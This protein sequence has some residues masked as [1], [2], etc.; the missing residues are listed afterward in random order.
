MI[1]MALAGSLLI[2]R[3][4][5]LSFARSIPSFARRWSGH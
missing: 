4:K 1:G 5:V 2:G 3:R